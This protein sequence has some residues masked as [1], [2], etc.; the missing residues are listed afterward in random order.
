MIPVPADVINHEITM[1][2]RL[3]QFR[4]FHIWLL[5]LLIHL[6]VSAQTRNNDV[7]HKRDGTKVEARIL[8][9]DQQTI[10]YKKISDPNGPTFHILKSD[11]AKV[12]YGNGESETFP[13]VDSRGGVAD[14]NNVI[15]YS[16]Y[17]WT[18]RNFTDDLSIWRPRQLTSGYKFYQGKEKSAKTLGLTFA[19]M[20][21]ATT[22]VGILMAANNKPKEYYGYYHNNQNRDIGN[23]LIIAG[24]STGIIVGVISAV[25]Y[26]K[27]HRRALLVKDE[28][29]KRN[30]PLSGVRVLPHYD[31]QT[32][33]AGLS[34]RFSF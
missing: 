16:P 26:G 13:G 4:H 19:A 6:E 2:L 10:Q 11:V 23:L 7:I 14:D 24:L 27:Y 20:G 25:T 12:D 22:I 32:K 3:T 5:C 17:P 9:V 34:L 1:E 8:L 30:I 28:L 18:Q 15:L 31:F 33:N 21:G 29:G